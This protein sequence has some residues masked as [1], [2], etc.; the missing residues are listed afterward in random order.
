M[1]PPNVLF[2]DNQPLLTAVIPELSA[3]GVWSGPTREPL[4]P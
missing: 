4:D 2:P 3:M 1:L